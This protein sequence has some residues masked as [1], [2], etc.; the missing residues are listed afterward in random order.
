[1]KLQKIFSMLFITLVMLGF[2]ASVNAQ[3]AAKP[4]S[5]FPVSPVTW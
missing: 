2:A 4:V 3:D 1:M 5:A